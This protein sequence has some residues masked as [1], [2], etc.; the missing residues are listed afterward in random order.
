MTTVRKIRADLAGEPFRFPA[1]KRARLDAL[2]DEDIER[3]GLEDPDNPPL[4]AE[5]LSRMVA[6]RTVRRVRERAGLSQANFAE[7]YRIPLR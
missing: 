2:F 6:A 5:E 1:E 3:L 7:R 4:T